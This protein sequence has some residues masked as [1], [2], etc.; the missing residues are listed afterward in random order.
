M[1]IYFAALLCSLYFAYFSKHLRKKKKT[2]FCILSALPLMILS[3]I[4]YDVGTDYFYTYAPGFRQIAYHYE[5]QG[6]Q[7]E[8]GYRL[9]NVI[10]TWFTKDYAW[11]FVVTSVLFGSFTYYHIYKRS[12][13]ALLSIFLYVGMSVFF[14]S[15]NA[16]RQ[17]LAL[18]VA[19]F[20]LPYLQKKQFAPFAIIIG[21]SSLI[22]ISMLILIPIYFLMVI[23]WDRKKMIILAAVGCVGIY[24]GHKM[25]G[26]LFSLSVFQRYQKYLEDDVVGGAITTAVCIVLFGLAL[27]SR[28]S[29]NVAKATTVLGIWMGVA[30]FF[31]PLVARFLFVVNYLEMLFLPNIIRNIENKKL[32]F[33]ITT[34]CV[35][36]FTIYVVY[37]I[38]VKGGQEVLPYRTIFSR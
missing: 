28:R 15:M 2:L 12:D 5:T 35:V 29:S 1:L 3:A 22:H 13:H 11:L 19:L 10:I 33:V 9:L 27:L 7:F 34:G 18:S 4:R 14:V 24:I 6:T 16:V 37:T 17:M 31:I 21:L 20:A 26:Y 30:S 32:R 38:G 25:L 36:C 8:P 23:E